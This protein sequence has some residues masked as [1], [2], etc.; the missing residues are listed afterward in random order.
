MRQAAEGGMAVAS[1]SVRALTVAP[2]G[3]MPCKKQTFA[4]QMQ[5][6]NKPSSACI[7]TSLFLSVSRMLDSIWLVRHCKTARPFG[8]TRRDFQ[9]FS[10]C[11]MQWSVIKASHVSQH[12]TLRQGA[13]ELWH[14]LFPVVSQLLNISLVDTRHWNV[15]SSE[16]FSQQLNFRLIAQTHTNTN[17][18]TF[19]LHISFCDLC[20]PMIWPKA[21]CCQIWYRFQLDSPQTAQWHL[22]TVDGDEPICQLP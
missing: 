11:L 21:D 5:D 14:C 19:N 2:R 12:S 1:T 4:E 6:C 20:P 17:I 8:N 18:F 15:K 3:T 13:N 9:N 16:S 7:A 10:L 22:A